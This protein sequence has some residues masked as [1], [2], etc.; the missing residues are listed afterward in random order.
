MLRLMFKRK[1]RYSLIDLKSFS[2]FLMLTNLFEYLRI[3]KTDKIPKIMVIIV[4][5][6]DINT[7][8]EMALS[9]KIESFSIF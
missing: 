3:T 7:K 2:P 4:K 5:K 6:L 8:L 1:N 9:D